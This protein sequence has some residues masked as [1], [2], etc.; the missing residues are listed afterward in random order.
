[1]NRTASGD[2]PGKMLAV[3]RADRTPF[4]RTAIF[5]A[6]INIFYFVPKVRKI[7]SAVNSV[8]VGS[9]VEM[10]APLRKRAAFHY[11]TEPLTRVFWR[12]VREH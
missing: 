3:L 7:K 11:M 2:S 9:P 8:R 6:M 4:G 12:S 1:M 10:L 5:G